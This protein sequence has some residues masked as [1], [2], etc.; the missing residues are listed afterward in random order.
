MDFAKLQ[1]EV[2]AKISTV[3]LF[4]TEERT[5]TTATKANYRLEKSSVNY[6]T[7]AQ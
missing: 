1:K 2:Y 7:S 4:S 6:H 3:E 5:K